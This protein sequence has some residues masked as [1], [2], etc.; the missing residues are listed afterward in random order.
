PPGG[1]ARVPS[2]RR[3]HRRARDPLPRQGR[4]RGHALPRVRGRIRA[5]PRALAPGPWRRRGMRFETRAVHAGGK[6]D[7]ATGAVAPPIHLATT[8]EHGP[9]AETPLGYL[10][11]RDANPTQSRLEEALAAIEGGETALVFGSGMGAAAAYLQ[12][13]PAGTHVVYPS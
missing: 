13:Q 1:G 12:A 4:P 2:N 5:R 11:V 9:A 8:F 10:Y 3:A 6:P 7:P